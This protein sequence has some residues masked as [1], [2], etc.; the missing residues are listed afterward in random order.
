MII[1]EQFCTIERE[2]GILSVLREGEASRETGK[3]DQGSSDASESFHLRV[4]I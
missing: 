2:V 4:Q 1:Q 3:K